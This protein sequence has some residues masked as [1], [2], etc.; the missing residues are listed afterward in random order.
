MLPLPRSLKVK[1]IYLNIHVINFHAIVE[2][3]IGVRIFDEITFRLEGEKAQP[4]LWE[5]HGFRM[6]IP[7]N[8]LSPYETCHVTV[9]AIDADLF[10]FPEGTEPV[11]AV[12]AISLTKPLHEPAKLE[13]EHC[14]N[15]GRAE[16]S[17]FMSFVVAS[18]EDRF[19]HF[20]KFE[21]L[22]GGIFKENT[23]Y[24]SVDRQQFSFFSIVWRYE[25]ANQ[26][27]AENPGK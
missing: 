24:G 12:Y 4:L 2:D 17:K 3:L 14:M 6:F 1:L 18:Q 23:Y 26:P 21:L 11:S 22:P 19:S 27:Q 20:Y 5:E 7:E 15:L 8:A 13:M 9:K 10:H 25:E 16:S